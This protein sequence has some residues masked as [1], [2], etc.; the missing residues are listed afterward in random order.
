MDTSLP[1]A[2]IHCT[3]CG[4]DLHPGEEQ[5]FLTCPYCSATV[6]LDRSRVVFHWFLAPTLD[7]EK[8]RASLMRWM[9]GNQ[10][11]KDLDRKAKLLGSTFEFFPLWYFKRKDASNK[12]TVLLFPA[13][14]TSISELR[15]L[16][17][18]AGDLRKYEQTID[19]QAI[20]PTVPLQTA[21]NWLTESQADQG[22]ITAQS[23]VHV[24]IYTFKYSYQG[25]V[26]TAVVEAGTGGIFANLYP[27]KAETPYRTMGCATA[28]IFFFLAIIPV[29]WS[30]VQG[31]TGTGLGLAVCFGLGLIFVPILFA[32]AA[33]IAAKV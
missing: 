19:S 15:R 31:A 4:G 33:W 17:L 23:L 25:S 9:A 26:Y 29:V 18:P 2:E 21:Q 24:P 6:Y 13:A 32:I 7:E 28:A 16:N 10:T 30:S 3:Q 27:A 20:P 12:E 8:A 1:V 22:E 11:V 5:I 14:A